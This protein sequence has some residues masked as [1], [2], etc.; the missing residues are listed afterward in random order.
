[1]CG[2]YTLTATTDKLAQQFEV[3]QPESL[4]PRYNI[5]P[6]Q[7]IPAIAL[8]GDSRQ[9]K[10]MRWGLIPHWVKDLA[11]WKANLINARAETVDSKPS[12]KSSFKQ[13]RCLIPATGFYE[14]SNDKQPYYFSLKDSKLFAFAGLWESW[15]GD[16]NEA[17]ASCTIITTKA[18]DLAAEVHHRMPVIIAPDDYQTWLSGDENEAHNLLQ[19]YAATAMELRQVSKL[20][21]NPRNDKPECITGMH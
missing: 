12:F 17:I 16:G 1:M 18:K 8:E 7:T 19:P 5:A 20:V 6:S 13:R 15:Q 4:Q 14:W 21:N 3:K 10:L 2:R 9:L 11:E